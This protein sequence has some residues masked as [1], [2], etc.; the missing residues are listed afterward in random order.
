MQDLTVAFKEKKLKKEMDK[1]AQ[2]LK[3]DVSIPGFRKGRVPVHMIKERF[4]PQLR[5]ESL[6]KLIQEQIVDIIQQYEPFVYGPPVVKDFKEENEEVRL[7]LSLDIPPEIDID[8]SS[9]SIKEAKKEKTDISGELEKLREINSELK[10]VS[11]RV[12]KGDIVFLNVKNEEEV[13]PN[14]SYEIGDDFFSEKLKDRKI[15]EKEEIEIELPGDFRLR[16]FD[17]SVKSIKV[18]IVEIKEKVK[19]LLDDEFAKDLGFDNLNELKKNLIDNLKKESEKE[20]ENEMKY[21]VLKKA[22]DLVDDFEVSPSLVELISRRGLDKDEAADNARRTELLDSIALKEKMKVEDNELDEWMEKIADSDDE[23]FENL[24]EEAIRFV[25]QL[26]LRKKAL[27]FLFAKAK[28]ED[29]N[30]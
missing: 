3:K 5:S 9:I 10:S 30:A 2:E 24:G 4:G 26:I 13:I 16:G 6:Q 11:R 21:Q 14:Y 18:T 20:T 15:E 7:E 1:L 28:G 12:K 8:L 17:T 29:L 22:L 25:K 27:D 23:S 19:P